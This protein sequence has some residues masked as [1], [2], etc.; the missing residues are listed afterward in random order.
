MCYYLLYSVGLFHYLIDYTVQVIV[1]CSL[2][3][4]K[5]W[6]CGDLGFTIA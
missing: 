1:V 6:A 5:Y 3:V 4:Y 2:D